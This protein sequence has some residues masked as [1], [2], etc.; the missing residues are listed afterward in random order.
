MQERLYPTSYI[1][2]KHLGKAC[3]LI[4]DGRFSGGTSG[5]SIGHISP[6]A[7]AGGSIGLVQNG[8]IIVI[9]IPSRSI[10]VKL[11]DEELAARRAEEEKRGKEAFTPKYRNRVVSKALQAYASMVTSA[12]KGG[13]RE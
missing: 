4:T 5:L 11:S 8:D 10:S 13:V 1:K 3:A 2:S 7:A 6:E 9:D 12:D